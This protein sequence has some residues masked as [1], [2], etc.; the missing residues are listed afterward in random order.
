[1]PKSCPIYFIADKPILLAQFVTNGQRTDYGAPSMLIVTP[2]E[3][4]RNYYVFTT[5][6]DP[7]FFTYLMIVIDTSLVMGIEVD[8][9]LISSTGWKSVPGINF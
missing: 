6:D 3:Q 1:M 8:G 2:V 7:T 5:V 9:R 4:F